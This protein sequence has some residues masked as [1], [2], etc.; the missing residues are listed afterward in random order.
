MLERKR[1]YYLAAIVFDL[2]TE[3][4]SILNK[5]IIE[6]RNIRTREDLLY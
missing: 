2:D 6:L 5:H 1:L 4:L 3:Q